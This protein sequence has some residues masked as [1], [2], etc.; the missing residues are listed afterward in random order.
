MANINDLTKLT[1]QEA[2]FEEIN[3]EELEG[4]VGGGAL[5]DAVIGVLNLVV[6]VVASVELTAGTLTG[7][8]TNLLIPPQQ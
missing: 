3:E 7:S 2:M 1:N 8:L 5:T 6:G 4:V